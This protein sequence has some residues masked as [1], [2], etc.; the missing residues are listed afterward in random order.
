MHPVFSVSLHFHYQSPYWDIP[1]SELLSVL[2]PSPTLADSY[3]CH[4]DEFH[5]CCRSTQVL[6]PVGI[7]KLT[8]CKLSTLL[9]SISLMPAMSLQWCWAAPTL[10]TS[11]TE[12]DGITSTFK[13][14]WPLGPHVVY[15]CSSSHSKRMGTSGS[16]WKEVLFY[17]LY[18]DWWKLFYMPSLLCWIDWLCF[19][20]TRE[21]SGW[22]NVSTSQIHL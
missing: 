11:A 4:L 2:S 22:N 5:C 13:A 21:S 9:A 8:A 15:K 10:G 12:A 20:G 19:F 17:Q 3:L 18:I 6:H 1:S 14:W 16:F 7:N